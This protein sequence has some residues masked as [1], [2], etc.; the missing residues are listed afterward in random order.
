[1]KG[2]KVN[3]V[4]F[5]LPLIAIALASGAVMAQEPNYNLIDGGWQNFNP[6]GS[7]SADGWF[8]GGG[9]EL[10]SRKARFHLGAEIGQLG[11]SNVWEIG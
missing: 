11:S 10:K 2:S 6:D 7:S 1:V 8:L 9:F 4:K 5:V 3:Q